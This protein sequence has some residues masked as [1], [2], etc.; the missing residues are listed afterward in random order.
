MKK[1]KKL[2]PVEEAIKKKT[3]AE[4]NNDM[5][6]EEKGNGNN[7]ALIYTY[8]ADNISQLERGIENE[9]EEKSKAGIEMHNSMTARD[10]E[11]K[12]DEVVA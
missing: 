4:N 5:P 11:E 6:L 9:L 8:N 1:C 7:I 12:D 3:E 2:I 10:V